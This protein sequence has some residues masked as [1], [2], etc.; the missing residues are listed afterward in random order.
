MHT[1]GEFHG[2]VLETKPKSRLRINADNLCR[3]F[4]AIGLKFETEPVD[5]LRY[6]VIS[7][8]TGFYILSINPL[9][10]ICCSTAANI[11]INLSQR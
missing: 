7:D 2:I 1:C 8:D 5:R 11:Y 3:N 6:P 9:F 4:L 10:Y